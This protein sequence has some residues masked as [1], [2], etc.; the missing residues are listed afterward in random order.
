MIYP[1]RIILFL[2][3]LSNFCYAVTSV[4]VITVKR[5]IFELNK[6][7]VG[8]VEAI[9]EVYVKSRVEGYIEEVRFKEGDYVKKGQILYVIDQKPYIAEVE[10]AKAILEKAKAHLFKARQHLKRL[11][12]ASPESVSK[13][14]LD[15]ALADLMLAKAEL[16][17]AKARLK[18]AKI[19]LGYTLIKAPIDGI[20]GKSFLKEG[21]LVGPNTGP[22]C[23]I[24]QIDPIRVVYSVS[25][26]D[27]DEI[28][29]SLKKMFSVKL[30]LPDGSMYSECG[31]ID[32]VDNHVDPKTG[33][34]AIWAMFKNPKRL[35][36]PGMY[37][38]AIPFL[39]EKKAFI[40]VPQSAVLEDKK[41]KFVLVV[42]REEEVEIRRIKVSFMAG[43]EWVVK[44][45]L[46]EGE[47]V[48]VQGIL[49]VRPGQKVKAFE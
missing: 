20:V 46:K 41:G 40:T 24:V 22:L 18:K 6:E 25:E 8:R 37:V 29:L 19:N 21:N 13:I 34:I 30:K 23:R 9:R 3:F 12:S 27:L 4:R 16:L 43:T 2:I 5:K 42:N 33:T 49:K 14:D 10:L 44:E 39:K 31:E 1:M 38:I 17:E 45:G 7:Y 28:Q 47:K 35:L 15:D 48:I 32:F 11:R 36:E 26:K